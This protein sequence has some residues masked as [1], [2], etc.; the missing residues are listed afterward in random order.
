MDPLTLGL[1][2]LRSVGTLFALQG[3][4]EVGSTINSVLEA[5]SAGKN[6]DKHLADIA[7]A[8][9]AGAD[10]ATWDDI[11]SRIDAEVDAFL[12]EPPPAA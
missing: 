2:A 7:D 11:T 8:L 9:E 4:P 12:D 6:V 10:L 5:Y 1:I 3:R